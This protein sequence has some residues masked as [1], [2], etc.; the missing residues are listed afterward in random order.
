MRYG[1]AVA[2]R[3]PR[4]GLHCIIAGG[5]FVLV[6][7]GSGS[8]RKVAVNNLPAQ[9]LSAILLIHFHSDH[10]GDL[11]EALMQSWAAGRNHKLEVYGPPGVEQVVAGFEQ[12]YSLDT[13][14]RV[15]HHGEE[16]MPRA[17]AGAIAQPIKLKSNEATALVFE[18]NGLKVTAFKVEHDPASSA[19]GYRFEYRGR[20]VVVSA[21]LQRATISRDTRQARICSFTM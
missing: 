8:W 14:Y 11:G 16:W 7:T 5:E 19:Y 4:T 13:G 12:A 2:R 15:Q 18:R 6:D 1:L 3:Q 20:V 10:I 17:A 9:N 21:T